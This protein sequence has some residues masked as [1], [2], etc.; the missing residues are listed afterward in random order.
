MNGKGVL[1]VMVA[2]LGAALA[3]AP[4]ASADRPIRIVLDDPP[5]ATGQFCE[6]FE[7]R[8]HTTRNNEVLTIFTSGAAL[9]TG[10]LRVEVTNVE[11]DET[12]GLNIPGP[13]RFSADGS[14]LL[15]TGPWLVFGAEGDLGEDSP[16]Q[17]NFVTGRLVLTFDET[18]S[19]SSFSVLSGRVVDICAA[20]AP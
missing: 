2:V 7:V 10:A 19:V 13:G 8:V 9:V 12:I 18:G 16:P 1:L 5:D 6:D 17:M 14:T 3:L 15:G 4:L 20:L 11:T